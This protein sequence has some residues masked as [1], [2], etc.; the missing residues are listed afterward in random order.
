MAK[1]CVKYRRMAGP[2]GMAFDKEGNL[3]VCVLQQGDIA[4]LASDSSIKEHLPIFGTFPTNIVFSQTSE[5]FI[6]CYRMI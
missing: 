4:I 3:Y 2:D 1:P 6:P 5:Q